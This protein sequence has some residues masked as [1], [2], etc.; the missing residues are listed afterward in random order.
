MIL[1]LP[2]ALLAWAFAKP[3]SKLI[4]PSSTA[5]LVAISPTNSDATVAAQTETTELAGS[6]TPLV[7]AKVEEDEEIGQVSEDSHSEVKTAPHEIALPLRKTD[8]G[9]VPSLDPN[10]PGMPELAGNRSHLDDTLKE[11]WE[12]L[13]LASGAGDRYEGL[14][15][16]SRP[17]WYNEMSPTRTTASW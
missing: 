10:S 6:Q 11:N 9:V 15:Q 3:P 13:D 17:H 5:K 4:E 8:L 1:A 7:L 2:V 16:P 12:K 14:R